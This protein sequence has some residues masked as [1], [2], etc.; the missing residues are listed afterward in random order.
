MT[1][2]EE[3]VYIEGQQAIWHRILRECIT[4]LAPCFNKPIDKH[5]GKHL[6]ERTRTW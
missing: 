4:N 5:L 3:L 1:E 6:H 2:K